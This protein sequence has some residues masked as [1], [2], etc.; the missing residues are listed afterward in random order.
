M[1]VTVRMVLNI[2]IMTSRVYLFVPICS[3]AAMTDIKIV[4]IARYYDTIQT[5]YYYRFA[6]NII[7]TA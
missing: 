3:Y 7:E 6:L 4:T 5:Y 2:V 1:R